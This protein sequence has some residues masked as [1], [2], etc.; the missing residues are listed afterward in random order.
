MYILISDDEEEKSISFD[1]LP[2]LLGH[3]IQDILESDSVLQDATCFISYEIRK[4]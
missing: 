1:T 4:E 2:E 3:L